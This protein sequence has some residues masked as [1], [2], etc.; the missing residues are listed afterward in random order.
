MSDPFLKWA[1]GKRLLV[2]RIKTMLPPGKRL[3]EPFVGS[4]AVGLATAYPA[5]L[6]GDNNPHLINLYR[7][8]QD[9]GQSFVDYARQF[10]T[11]ASNT[12]EHY[13]ALRGA[14]LGMPAEEQA[15]TFLYFNKHGYNGLCRFNRKGGFNVPF[16]RFDQ[17]YFPE[18]EMLYFHAWAQQARFLCMD[19]SG[20]MELAEAGDV[21][22]CDPPY[23]PL[24][25][26]ANFTNYSVGGF[27][28]AEQIQLVTLASRLA[29]RGVPV[30]ISNHDTPF[31]RDLYKDAKQID[32]F[33]VQRNISCNGRRRRKAPELLALFI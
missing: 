17:P 31:T 16:G 9:H 12:P 20:V 3:I 19:F 21:V 24:S 18:P 7:Q 29:A 30:L 2:P 33:E 6:L 27:G 15:A 8:L 13:Y 5:Y 1:G 14:F 10:F 26:T 11:P 22:Y 32:Y 4:A 25:P 28:Q 23:V